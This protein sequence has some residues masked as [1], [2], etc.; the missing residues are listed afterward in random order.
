MRSKE[1]AEEF[2]REY[3]EA[4]SAEIQRELTAR[5]PFRA[6]YYDP[7]C[8]WDSYPLAVELSKS[9]RIVSITES[10]G[11]FVIITYRGEYSPKLRYTLQDT[12]NGLLIFSVQPECTIC[13]G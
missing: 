10:N 13:R 11:S 6:K 1:P 7:S 9:E 3:F 2:M 4:R 12:G 8:E 5:R